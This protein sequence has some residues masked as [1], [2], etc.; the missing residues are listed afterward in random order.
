MAGRFPTFKEDEITDSKR[1]Q[2][3]TKSH[4]NKISTRKNLFL[5]YNC[6]GTAEVRLRM[7]ELANILKN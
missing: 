3:D 5:P 4:L 1:L 2:K 6:R 7:F